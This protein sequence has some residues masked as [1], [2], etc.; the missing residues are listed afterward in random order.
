MDFQFPKVKPGFY[1]V[2]IVFKYLIISDSLPGHRQETWL[3]GEGIAWHGP[4][5]AKVIH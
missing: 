3:Y 1:A 2:K 4:P 5:R